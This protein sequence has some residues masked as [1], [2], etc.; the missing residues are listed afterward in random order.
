MKKL[1][2]ILMLAAVVSTTTGCA[3][4]VMT[5]ARGNT[6]SSEDIGAL[7]A[8]DD[9][10]AVREKFG[11]PR[12][13]TMNED[14]TRAVSWVRPGLGGATGVNVLFGA[15]NKLVRVLAKTE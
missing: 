13:I 8:G 6:F 5:V 2:A 11:K 4:A 9:Y 12:K 3:T 15:D 10:D 14:G 7:K 1:L